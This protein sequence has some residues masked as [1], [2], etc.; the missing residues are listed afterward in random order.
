M[1]SALAA[2]ACELVF[3]LED[4]LADA[5]IP[6][7]Q[8]EPTTAKKIFVTRERFDGNLGGP[9]GADEKCNAAAAAVELPGTYAAW[10]STTLE[11]ARDRVTRFMGPYE[12]LDGTQIA[13]SFGQ[14]LDGTLEGPIDITEAGT[15][16]QSNGTPSCAGG[17]GVWTN[18][19]EQGTAIDLDCNGFVSAS[20][21]ASNA[22]N[23]SAASAAW[24]DDPDCR[25][26][27]CGVENA[28][29]CFEQ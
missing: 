16:L 24:T 25:G 19:A 18:T 1:V 17:L 26:L 21:S 5:G 9:A 4:K 12:L 23:A 20:S 13:T 10:I 29:Y 27:P 28:L 7:T 8:V 14:L 2:S 22:G 11:N 6:D 3:P 15:D